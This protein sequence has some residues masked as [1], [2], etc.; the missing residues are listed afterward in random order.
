MQTT[1]INSC[2]KWAASS[3]PSWKLQEEQNDKKKQ[4]KTG[5]LQPGVAAWL[6]G[7]RGQ[8]VR[9]TFFRQ[10]AKKFIKLSATHL[11]PTVRC[12]FGLRLLLLGHKATDG[13]GTRDRHC[14]LALVTTVGSGHRRGSPGIPWPGLSDGVRSRRR[15]AYTNY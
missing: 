12:L 14:N 9:G 13:N 10:S 3:I 5:N 6:P 8:M 11:W 4:K 7:K 2:G 1:R 15:G